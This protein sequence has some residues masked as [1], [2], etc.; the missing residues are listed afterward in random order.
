MALDDA[1]IELEIVMRARLRRRMIED[2]LALF[3]WFCADRY[4][5]ELRRG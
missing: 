4:Y 3:P 2:P 1:L 5:E